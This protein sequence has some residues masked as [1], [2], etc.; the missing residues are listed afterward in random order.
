M[1]ASSSTPGTWKRRCNGAMA[2]RGPGPMSRHPLAHSLLYPACPLNRKLAAASHVG[3]GPTQS[4]EEPTSER[5]ALM[6]FTIKSFPR[7]GV[8]SCLAESWRCGQQLAPRSATH[9]AQRDDSSQAA[10]EHVVPHSTTTARGRKLVGR[11]RP[12]DGSPPPDSAGTPAP[13]A[14]TCEYLGYAAKPCTHP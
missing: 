12:G 1:P 13:V 9:R 7:M 5:L 3:G 4:N 10:R 8:V 2:L 11:G 14:S 6:Q